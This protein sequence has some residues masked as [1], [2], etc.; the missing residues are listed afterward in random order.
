MTESAVQKESH[1]IL[2]AHLFEESLHIPTFEFP[3][4]I[5]NYS[6]IK[7]LGETS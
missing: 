4:S 5:S 7:K 3:V 6:L 2:T 1:V